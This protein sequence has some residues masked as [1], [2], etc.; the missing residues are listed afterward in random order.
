MPAFFVAKDAV[1]AAFAAGKSNGLVVSCGSSMTS[2]VPIYEGY[3]LKKGELR[4]DSKRRR[5]AQLRRPIFEGAVKQSLA[6]NAVS[7]FALQLLKARYE[8]DVVPQ[9]LVKSKE[10]TTAGQ[11]PKFAKR[12][13]ANTTESFHR[14]H[15][16][17]GYGPLGTGDDF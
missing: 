1:L 3:A 17:V 9:Y 12:D 7:E 6:G 10:V 16:L 2:V 11:Q 4:A 13:L 15:M 8:L 5:L 14:H